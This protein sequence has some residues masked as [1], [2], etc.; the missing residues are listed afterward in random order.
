MQPGYGPVSSRHEKDAADG[1]GNG[2]TGRGSD[3]GE[4]GEASRSPPALSPAT[5][6]T[7]E[8]PV[9]AGS[10]SLNPWDVHSTGYDPAMGPDDWRRWLF[11][12]AAASPAQNDGVVVDMDAS[13]RALLEGGF[14]N[15]QVRETIERLG[16]GDSSSTTLGAIRI[17]YLRSHGRTAYVPGERC[18]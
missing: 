11:A 6:P 12:S 17:K 2:G 18:M 8:P 1:D 9:Q 7:L 10:S 3:A 5:Q 4:L 14:N 16:T 15:D 13:V